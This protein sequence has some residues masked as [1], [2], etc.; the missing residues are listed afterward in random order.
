MQLYFSG[1][2]YCLH[3]KLTA[4]WNFRHFGQFDQSKICTEVSFTLPEIMWMLIIKLPHTKVKFYPE[5]K[6]QTA[7]DLMYMCSK[8]DQASDLWQQLELL[9]KLNLIYKI[10]QTG[11]GSGLLIPVLDTFWL[12]GWLPTW[13]YPMYKRLLC[14]VLI[15]PHFDYV[16]SSW[17]PLSK[18]NLEFKLQKAQN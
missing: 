13:S 11:V 10:S 17:F 3:G 18:K 8:C 2:I 1:G 4:V 5:V 15:Q 12:V 16:C 9:L 6:S 7:S 14:N